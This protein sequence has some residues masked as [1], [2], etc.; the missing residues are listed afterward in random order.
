MASALD[1]PLAAEREAA[2]AYA[3]MAKAENTWRA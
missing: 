2:D 3:R 1:G